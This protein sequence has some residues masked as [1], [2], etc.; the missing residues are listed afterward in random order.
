MNTKHLIAEIRHFFANTPRSSSRQTAELEQSLKDTSELLR[1]RIK[2]NTALIKELKYM[3]DIYL[4]RSG[5][6]LDMQFDSKSRLLLLTTTYEANRK[7]IV[8]YIPREQ[9]ELA[10]I[11]THPSDDTLVIDNIQLDFAQCD[12]KAGK[13]ILQE[14]ITQSRTLGLSLII[15]QFGN[16]SDISFS[17][18]VQ[19]YRRAGFEVTANAIEETGALQYRLEIHPS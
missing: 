12:I 13:L 7:T 1:E 6:R 15:G 11:S 14:L 3:Y 9:L 2:E 10:A 18:K 16:T 19:F 5:C 17:E 4:H 8:I